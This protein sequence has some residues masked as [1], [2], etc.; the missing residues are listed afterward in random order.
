MLYMLGKKS[1]AEIMDSTR[2]DYSAMEAASTACKFTFNPRPDTKFSDRQL[3]LIQQAVQQTVVIEDDPVQFYEWNPQGKKKA[4]IVHGIGSRCADFDEI[5]RQLIERDFRVI[6]FDAP[7]HG[8]SPLSPKGVDISNFWL[9][10]QKAKELYGESYDLALGH[11]FGS[12][13]LTLQ[14]RKKVIKADNLVLFAPNSVFDSILKSFLRQIKA[15]D[16]VYPPLSDLTA[17]RFLKRRNIPRDILWNGNSPL[18]NVKCLAQEAAI[19]NA[20]FIHGTKDTMFPPAESQ[21]IN[22]A[23]APVPSAVHILENAGHKTVLTEARTL[24]IL[25]DFYERVF[26]RASA[27]FLPSFAALT[28]E[29]TA[30]QAAQQALPQRRSPKSSL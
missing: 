24:E 22:Q 11:S 23:C 27:S 18:E 28:L 1:F 29:T 21:A 13:A 5:I 7:S 2:P 14:M 17:E 26:P 10:L 8:N 9:C 25:M 16:D 6:A 4:L 19:K 3:T 15:H 20:L 30:A 12:A